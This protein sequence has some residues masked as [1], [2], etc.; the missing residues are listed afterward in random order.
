MTTS[1]GR[2]DLTKFTV[3]TEEVKATGAAST[4]P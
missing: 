2:T 1:F 4:S 3:T